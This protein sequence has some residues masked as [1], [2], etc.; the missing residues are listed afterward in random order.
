MINIENLKMLHATQ[1]NMNK[2]VAILK[3]DFSII[4]EVWAWSKD[5]QTLQAIKGKRYQVFIDVYMGDEL[6]MID[7]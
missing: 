5:L 1:E 3:Q 6:D 7:D 4:D 2:M